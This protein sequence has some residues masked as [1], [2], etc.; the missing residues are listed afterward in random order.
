MRIATILATV[1]FLVLGGCGDQTLQEPDHGTG[2]E[3]SRD[4]TASQDSSSTSS[5]YTKQDCLDKIDRMRVVYISI[6]RQ[7]PAIPPLAQLN[8]GMQSALN[9]AEEDVQNSQFS[10]CVTELTRQIEFDEPYAR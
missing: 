3:L 10:K 9:D 2:A 4:S 8:K 7:T 1:A 6:L 5:G